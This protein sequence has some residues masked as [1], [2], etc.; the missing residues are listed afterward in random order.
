VVVEGDGSEEVSQRNLES[1]GD[2]SERLLG[3]ETVSI[4]EGM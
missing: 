2:T 3:D 1:P 4:V